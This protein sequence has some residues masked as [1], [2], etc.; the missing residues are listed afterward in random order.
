MLLPELVFLHP[1]NMGVA[2]GGSTLSN[3]ADFKKEIG[4]T[5]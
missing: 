3:N 4:I 2:K 1:T 5:Q